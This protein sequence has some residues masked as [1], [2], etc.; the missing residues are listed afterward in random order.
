MNRLE[1]ALWECERH[2][3][4]IDTALTE[5]AATPLPASLD[6]LENDPERLRLVDQLLFRFSKLQDAIGMRLIPAT[7]TYLEEPYQG[8]PMRD[9]LDRLERLGYLNAEDWLL[10]R[11]LRNRLAHEYP[12]EPAER[13]ASLLAALSAARALADLFVTWRDRLPPAR[14]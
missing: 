3:S 1:Q 6:S 7:L 14:G 10:W 8:W 2:V 12:G 13:L 9:R 5:F 11:E 4:V